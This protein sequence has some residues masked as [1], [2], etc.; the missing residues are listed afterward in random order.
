MRA[1][2]LVNPASGGRRGAQVLQALRARQQP[3]YDVRAIRLPA[4]LAQ[5]EGM[6]VACGGDGT[7][8]AVLAA[9]AESGRALPVAVLPL[10]TGN[11]LARCL[12]WLPPVRAASDLEAWLAH[13]IAAPEGV[14]DRWLLSGPGGTRQ[15]FNYC[16]WGFDAAVA[17]RFHALRRER[18]WLV[19]GSRLGRAAYAVNGLLTRAVALRFTTLPRRA[20]SLVCLSI[21]SYAGGRRLGAG[22]RADDGLCDLFLL[23]AGLPLAWVMLGWRPALA[24]GQFRCWRLRLEQPLPMQVDGEPTIAAPG[25]WRVRHAGRLRVLLGPAALRAAG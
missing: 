18:P 23:P 15:W 8:S 2:F 5:W 20:G 16:S 22:V 14:I 9:V 17:R 11:D 24:L 12:G 10:G 13:A 25:E 21:P 7:V 4:L 3:A 1:C 6:I 19:R